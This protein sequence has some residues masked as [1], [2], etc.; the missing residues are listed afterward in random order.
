MPLPVNFTAV[1]V[2]ITFVQPVNGSPNA[3]VST[4]N[5]NL[6]AVSAN[7]NVN[8]NEYVQNLLVRGYWNGLQFIPAKQITL[9][10]A[11]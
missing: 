10:T 11:S 5:V 7:V 3:N 2:A 9:I 1:Q 6:Q 4:V 8:I